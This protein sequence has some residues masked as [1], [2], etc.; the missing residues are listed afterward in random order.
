MKLLLSTLC[1]IGG[2]TNNEGDGNYFDDTAGNASTG[3]SRSESIIPWTLAELALAI[4]E[5]GFDSNEYLPYQDA[6]IDYFEWRKT[7]AKES[8]EYSGNNFDPKAGR[9]FYYGNLGFTLSELTGDPIYREGDG[10]LNSDGTPLGAI[11]FLNEHLGTGNEPQLPIPPTNA[12]QEGAHIGAY[13]RGVPFLKH[14][15]LGEAVEDRNQWWDFGVDPTIEQNGNVFDIREADSDFYND[16][17]DTP[18]AH[19][20]GRELLAGI[21]RAQWF[22]YTGGINPD[23][24]YMRDNL[25]PQNLTTDRFGQKTVE[26]WDYI[27]NNLWD[28][29]DGQQ[30]WL[31]AVGHGYKPC[32]S[33]GNDAPI[34]DWLAP[35]IG[36]KV[37]SINQDS[38]ALVTV[39]GVIDENTPFMS[40]EFSAS[41][42][43]K[44]EV[45]YTFDNGNTWT[46][47]PAEFDGINYVATIPEAEVGTTVYYY[48]KAMD[49]FRNWTAFPEGSEKWDNEGNSLL[50]SIENSQTYTIQEI[51]PINPQ[52]ELPIEETEDNTEEEEENEV[53]DDV[54]PVGQQG[55]GDGNII[56]LN[57]VN[58]QDVS[59][60]SPQADPVTG[61]GGAPLIRTGGL[62]Y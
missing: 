50:K 24:Y 43:N 28:D 15:D 37:H 25:E 1:T 21:Q 27:N 17:L 5:A 59:L 62:K 9:D 38:S 51:N 19:Y 26:Y 18:F 4:K 33:G 42:I 56:D 23:V 22:F 57:L 55:G 49:N 31:E 34:G 16:K 7:T 44:V 29:T 30:A 52:E 46:T 14:R 3:A 41:G 45:E 54:N 39:S 53:P 35:K 11:P 48:A 47:I 20:R 32:F 61:A 8:P 40:W 60:V 2:I 12:L 10:S 58:P 36:D 6:A 13:G